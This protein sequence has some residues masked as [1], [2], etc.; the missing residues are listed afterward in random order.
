[1]YYYIA[2]P[3][4]APAERRKIESV[5]S[6][7]SQLGIAGE[8]AV[9]S[10]ARSV[11][12]HLQLAFAKGFTTIVSIGSDAL[13]SKVA[14]VMLAQR[15]EK[16]ALGVIPI[17]TGQ[18]FWSLTGVKSLTEVG[19]S[20]RT[21]HLISIDALELN[22]GEVCL[23]PAQITLAK[24]MR[25]QLSYKG[26]VIHGQLT[27][28][29]ILP[30]GEVTLWDRTFGQNRPIWQRLFGAKI[31]PQLA[32]SRFAGDH[33]QLATEQ[34]VEVMIGTSP[35]SRTPLRANRRP[36]ALKLIVNRAMITPEKSQPNGSAAAEPTRVS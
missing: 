8:F 16:A 25:F 21:R 14:G 19:E 30:S 27:D 26:A 36:K 13:A 23:S 29:E 2:E 5:K 31:D 33:W 6:L 34:P 4:S 7:L 15:Y 32:R 12:E 9:A 18:V 28:M 24:P 11:E 22:P 17:Q 1:M 10:P 35:I 3:V 20:L